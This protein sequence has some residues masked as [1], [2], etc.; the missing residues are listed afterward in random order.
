ML[1]LAQFIFTST[2]GHLISAAIAP[3]QYMLDDPLLDQTNR[4][5]YDNNG[6][7]LSYYKAEGRYNRDSDPIVISFNGNNAPAEYPGHTIDEEENITLSHSVLYIGKDYTSYS[8][9]YVPFERKFSII[10]LTFEEM[11]DNAYK[12]AKKIMDDNLGKKFIIRGHSLGGAITTLAMAKLE[13]EGY[14]AFF[15]QDRSFSSI[16]DVLYGRI[17][18]I[19]FIG[20][21]LATIS[22]P[23]I[24]LTLSLSSIEAEITKIYNKIESPKITFWSPKDLAITSEGALGT[25]LKD[26]T[27]VVEIK[28]ILDDLHI[29]NAPLSASYNTARGIP[30][31][32]FYDSKGTG[33]ANIIEDQYESHKDNINDI[34]TAAVKNNRLQTLTINLV[35][36][37]GLAANF[38][39][40]ALAIYFAQIEKLIN[41][42]LYPLLGASTVLITAVQIANALY[43]KDSLNAGLIFATI[44]IPIMLNAAFGAALHFRA[45]IAEA[46]SKAINHIITTITKENFSISLP[47][48]NTI[49]FVVVGSLIAAEIASIFTK[50][51]QDKSI[52]EEF[53]LG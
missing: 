21:V 17:C 50:M 5:E 9:N 46:I 1:S 8:C 28:S 36:H 49:P 27:S 2:L 42:E 12:I 40:G 10:P 39:G 32:I 7:K 37:L 47:G 29:H 4:I 45:E 33:I 23:L 31:P 30:Y 3:V 14:R 38:V 15:I 16:A 11:A 41:R 18:Q 22:Y 52:L 53:Y 24:K 51:I 34:K 13:A 20:K 6:S 43:N 48:T 19:P 25:K 44:A 26:K 35:L